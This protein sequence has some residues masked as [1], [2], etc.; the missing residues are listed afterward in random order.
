MGHV[1]QSCRDGGQSQQYMSGESI[2]EIIDQ[3]FFFADF[4]PHGLV[5][6]FLFFPFLSSIHL[7]V[8]VVHSHF[9]LICSTF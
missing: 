3:V 7:I 5:A 2:V 9:R 6:S 8:L 1:I 4:L